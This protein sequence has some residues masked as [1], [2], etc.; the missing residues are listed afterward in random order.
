VAKSQG[1]NNVQLYNACR[2]SYARIPASIDGRFCTVAADFH[3]MTTINVSQAGLLVLI[4]PSLA[5]GALIDIKLR[6]SEP[7]REIRCSGRV[8]RVEERERGLHEAA[9]R[10]TEI[11]RNDRLALMAYLKSIGTEDADEV[12]AAAAEPDR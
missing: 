9:V 10:I 5:V 8:I 4:D 2:R 12:F 3:P 11:G 1:R 7:A 6:V